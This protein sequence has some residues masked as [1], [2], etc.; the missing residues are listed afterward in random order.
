MDS[1]AAR[2]LE[3]APL[4]G[5]TLAIRQAG[6]PDRSQAYG[7]ANL[8]QSTLAAPDTIYQLGSLSM[9]FAAAAVMQLVEKGQINLD[10]PISQYLEGLPPEFQSLTLHQLLS[11]TSGIRE[12]DEAYEK[13]YS[14]QEFSSEMLLQE[15]VPTLE[16]DS[17]SSGEEHVSYGN[18]ILVGLVIEKVSG[19]SYADYVNTHVLAP[20]SLQHTRYCMPSPSKMARGYY[21][22][23]ET[24]DPVQLNASAFSAAGGLC[25]TAGDLAL[26]MDA[27]SSGKIV[28]PQSYQR[29]IAPTQSPN[30]SLNL[31][32]GLYATQ[33]DLGLNVGYMGIE[34]SFVSFL[35]SYP[36]Q[37]LT[38]VLLSNTGPPEGDCLR[39]IYSM[40]PI[41]LDR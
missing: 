2:C 12:W 26:W 25:G 34:G 28:Q 15:L 32:Y 16:I 18:Y 40:V 21:Y 20:A 9:P 10:V 1:S 39:E 38:V 17:F 35:T 36:E 33:D 30:D 14:Q 41:L 24:F 22:H 7:F 29:M 23:D 4:V 8:E 3:N 37:G 19:M 13:L 27:L 11:H 6:E 31:G 5:M